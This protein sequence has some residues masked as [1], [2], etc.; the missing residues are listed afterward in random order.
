MICIRFGR[1]DSKSGCMFLYERLYHRGYK[2]TP[3]CRVS[4]RYL[5]TMRE[6][7]KLADKSD[8]LVPPPISSDGIS[9]GRMSCTKPNRS[10]G[11]KKIQAIAEWRTLK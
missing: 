6:C 1:W 3:L 4:F 2:W 5:K 10:N 11:P 8:K 7:H 9:P